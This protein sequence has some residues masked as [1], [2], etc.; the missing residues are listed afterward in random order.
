MTRAVAAN[1]SFHSVGT[2]G[3]LFN[4][5]QRNFYMLDQ[6]C[7]FIRCKL[8]DSAAPDDVALCIKS[9]AW[10]HRAAALP[11]LAEARSYRRPDGKRARYLPLRATDESFP[12]RAIIFPRWRRETHSARCTR[13]E[14]PPALRRLLACL[15]PIGR[16]FSAADAD[17]LIR[18]VAGTPCY[19]LSYGATAPALRQIE[20]LLC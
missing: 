7:G 9:G 14:P 3:V 12:V 2:D 6:T 18:W 15:D 17:R 13:L 20:G 5:A 8:T 1:V 4:T 19:A 11:A 16:R 10:A